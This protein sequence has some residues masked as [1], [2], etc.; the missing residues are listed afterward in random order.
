MTT[1]N[2]RLDFSTLPQRRH[3]SKS[4][5]YIC[6]GMNCHSKHRGH[7][8]HEIEQ[9]IDKFDLIQCPHVWTCTQ[10]GLL[11]LVITA[12]QKQQ[13]TATYVK[14]MGFQGHIIVVTTLGVT[15]FSSATVMYRSRKLLQ[16]NRR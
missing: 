3:H 8:D 2:D 7:A 14:H 16:G 9:I 1:L 12:P 10:D 11:D 6:G 13:V 5:I 4:F 15:K